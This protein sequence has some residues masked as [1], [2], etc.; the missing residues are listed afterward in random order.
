MLVRVPSGEHSSS[1]PAPQC[2][3]PPPSFSRLPP[4]R[5]LSFPSSS[6]PSR[7]VY[8][9]L[10]S[11]SLLFVSG[12]SC[13]LGITLLFTLIHPGSLFVLRSSRS[14]QL[15]FSYFTVR[16]VVTV[17][18][19][20]RERA[21]WLK[22]GPCWPEPSGSNGC[23]PPTINCVTDDERD[24][25]AFKGGCVI[26]SAGEVTYYSGD[27]CATVL[28]SVPTNTANAVGI[29]GNFSC[30]LQLPCSSFP[31][32]HSHTHTHIHSLVLCSW[33]VMLLSF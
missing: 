10:P 20:P 1:P 21:P 16:P 14:F 13:S 30:W 8:F 18:L 32:T 17:S 12:C 2:V 26:Y 22:R 11:L 7:R 28:E 23:W 5:V 27:R 31:F 9:S 4:L 25:T 6:S 29:L 3:L 19:E 24:I 15:C 33:F